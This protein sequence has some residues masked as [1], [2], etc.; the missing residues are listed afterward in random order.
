[1]C[2]MCFT[3]AAVLLTGATSAAG[4]GT[5]LVTSVAKPRRRSH[6]DGLESATQ[7]SSFDERKQPIE[8]RDVDL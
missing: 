5:L 6:M 7:A 4:L 3:T 2:P 8:I 1:M